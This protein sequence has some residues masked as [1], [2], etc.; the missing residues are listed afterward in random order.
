MMNLSLIFSRLKKIFFGLTVRRFRYALQ[1]G[2]GAAIEHEKL[3]KNLQP[4][5]II[6]VGANV[7]QFALISRYACPK[8]E[9][10]SFEPLP[11]AAKTCR[12]VMN[13]DTLFTLHEFALG[14]K[15]EL[16]PLH[17]TKA[18]DSSSLLP[19]GK[20]HAKLY[21][22]EVVKL[23]T[24]KCAPL[25]DFLKQN[26]LIPKTLLKI[27]TQGFELQVLQGAEAELANI[28]WVYVELSFVELYEGQ[29]LATEVMAWLFARNYHLHGVYNLAYNTQGETIQADMLFQNNRVAT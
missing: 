3:L 18:N 15:R 20:K 1:Q 9:I 12:L 4:E 2:V 16:L 27:D 29:P 23:T 11:E 14:E 22:S 6:D 25:R 28:A 19:V 26:S 10:I 8:A 24:I 5:L 17:V 13:G 21:G 7:G